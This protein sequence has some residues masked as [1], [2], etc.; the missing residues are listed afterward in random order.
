MKV[1]DLRGAFS[2]T[3]ST[4]QLVATSASN[5]VAIFLLSFLTLLASGGAV[6]LLIRK[7]VVQPLRKSVELA[8]RIANS[9][10]SAADRAMKSAKQT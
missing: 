2:V 8:N 4:D 9:D 6:Y 5:S 1:G 7:L 10:L 3:A